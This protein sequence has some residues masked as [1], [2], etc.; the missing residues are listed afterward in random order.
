MTAF[1]VSKMARALKSA[2]TVGSSILMPVKAAARRLVMGL[3]RIFRRVISCLLWLVILA[4]AG[5][6]GLLVWL[7]YVLN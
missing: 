2:H 5:S 7:A 1:E 3:G 4:L 6:C